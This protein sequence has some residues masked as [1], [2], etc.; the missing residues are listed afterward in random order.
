MQD[1]RT[2]V[3]P[4]HHSSINHR[5]TL[6]QAFS[7][8]FKAVVVAYLRASRLAFGYDYGKCE[9]R[10][11]TEEIFERFVA[12]LTFRQLDNLGNR[13]AVALLALR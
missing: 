12:I 7:V 10:L 4:L 2:C 11:L 1:P 13:I 8:E 5:L 6:T 9:K 3:L